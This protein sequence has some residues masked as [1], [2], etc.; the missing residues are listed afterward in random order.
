MNQPPKRAK[1]PIRIN[2]P[3][4]INNSLSNK[5]IVNK[6]NVINNSLSNKPIVNKPNILNNSLNKPTIVN[7]PNVIKKIDIPISETIGGSKF[8]P[9]EYIKQN[10]TRN[11]YDICIIKKLIGKKILIPAKGLI[12]TNKIKQDAK[13]VKQQILTQDS[14]KNIIIH[15]V[16]INGIM[17][18]IN[19]YHNY[20]ALN[21]FSYKEVE[22]N[23]KLKKIEVKVI[24]LPKV[25]NIELKQLIDYFN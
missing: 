5:P 19:G 3:N 22:I 24:Q 25:S 16:C 14:I 23:D 13:I 7:K 1:S 4:V 15:V 8:S 18:I 21:S 20:L 11:L 12:L 17:N 9:V 10:A 2:K 6:P